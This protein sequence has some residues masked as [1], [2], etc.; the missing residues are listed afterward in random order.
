M[1][2]NRQGWGEMI[3]YSCRICWSASFRSSSETFLRRQARESLDI[4][5]SG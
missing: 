3:I 2:L 1:C 4:L 5:G